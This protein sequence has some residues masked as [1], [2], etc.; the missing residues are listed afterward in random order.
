MIKFDGNFSNSVFKVSK[1]ING[2]R[3]DVA[4]GKFEQVFE[5]MHLDAGSEV[6]RVVGKHGMRDT[7]VEKYLSDD[8]IV[9][10]MEYLG[11]DETE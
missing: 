1:I 3:V 5:L 2:E 8:N 4:E 6:S 11:K 9:Y 7:N 10:I